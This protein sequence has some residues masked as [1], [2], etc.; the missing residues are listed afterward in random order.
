[1]L[2]EAENLRDQRYAARERRTRASAIRSHDRRRLKARPAPPCQSV[3]R[4]SCEEGETPDAQSSTHGRIDKAPF[5]VTV[6]VG[7]CGHGTFW[8]GLLGIRLRLSD[9]ELADNLRDFLER[10]ECAVIEIDAE[11]LEV[12]LPHELHAEQARLELD[13]YL[14]VW[15]SLHE[16]SA[17]EY[18]EKL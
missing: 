5:P 10:R 18:V 7:H 1:M 2:Y 13:L 17:V 9:P 14:R 3:R 15:Q 8:E 12:E 11:T 16:W 6:R 4:D